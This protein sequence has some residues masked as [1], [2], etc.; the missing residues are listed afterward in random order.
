MWVA[1]TGS[2]PKFNAPHW[3]PGTG[4]VRFRDVI[5][6]PVGRMRIIFII[7]WDGGRTDLA[8]MVLLCR[9]HHRVLHGAQWSIQVVNDI[10]YFKPPKWVDSEQK[11]VRNVLRH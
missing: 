5:C 1:N 2:S 8:N 3:S 9:R 10:P 7:G 4:D 6:P 11:L